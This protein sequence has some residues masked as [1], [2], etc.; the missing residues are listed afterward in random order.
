MRVKEL[1]AER[2]GVTAENR[3][4]IVFFVN[5]A[6]LATES[7]HSR[8]LFAEI[9]NFDIRKGTS[10]RL[11]KKPDESEDLLSGLKPA[12]PPINKKENEF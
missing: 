2:I 8:T 3:K 10:E 7:N 4:Y 12:G 11:F 6:L 9:D 1:N 5:P